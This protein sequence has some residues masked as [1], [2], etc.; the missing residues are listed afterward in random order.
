MNPKK[1]QQNADPCK[2]NPIDI[3]QAKIYYINSLYNL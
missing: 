1:T 3:V 2:R